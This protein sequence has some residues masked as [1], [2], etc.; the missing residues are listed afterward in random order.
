MK[1]RFEAVGRFTPVGKTLIRPA[2]VV[3]VTVTLRMAAFAPPNGTPNCPAFFT[4]GDHSSA[5]PLR[6]FEV[7]SVVEV[8]RQWVTL[9]ESMMSRPWVARVNWR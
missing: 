4:A 1:F 6:I 8:A 3:S 2:T 5:L 7:R 9:Q